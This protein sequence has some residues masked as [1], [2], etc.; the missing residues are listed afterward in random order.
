MEK[1]RQDNL[2]VLTYVKTENTINLLGD[3]KVMNNILH[4]EIIEMTHKYL[5]K[6]HKNHIRLINKYQP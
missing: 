3:L 1:L 5:K 6:T 4:M 2:L